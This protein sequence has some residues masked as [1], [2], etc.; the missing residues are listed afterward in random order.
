MASSEPRIQRSVWLDIHDRDIAKLCSEGVKQDNEITTRKK[1]YGW[2]FTSLTHLSEELYGSLSLC[3]YIELDFAEKEFKHGYAHSD[4]SKEQIMKNAIT[5][6]L[7][8][9]NSAS[10]AR[11]P[12]DL[13]SPTFWKAIRQLL[14]YLLGPSNPG[15]DHE[16]S[17]IGKDLPK[18]ST[19]SLSNIDKTTANITLLC[20]ELSIAPVTL[21]IKLLVIAYANVSDRLQTEGRKIEASC[22]SSEGGNGPTMGMNPFDHVRTCLTLLTLYLLGMRHS[23]HTRTLFVSSLYSPSATSATLQFL[24]FRLSPPTL[25]HVLLTLAFRAINVTSNPPHPPLSLDSSPQYW[26][27]TS[28]CLILIRL[29]L[30]WSIPTHLPLLSSSSPTTDQS[31]QTLPISNIESNPI[32]PITYPELFPSPRSIMDSSANSIPTVLSYVPSASPVSPH[33]IADDSFHSSFTHSF[34]QPSL[35][36]SMQHVDWSD[37]TSDSLLAPLSPL[38][39][40]HP[41]CSLASVPF[42][43]SSPSSLDDASSIQSH[44]SS[45]T[46]IPPSTFQTQHG[47]LFIYPGLFTPQQR[48]RM[49]GLCQSIS[50]SLRPLHY[51]DTTLGTIDSTIPLFTSTLSPQVPKGIGYFLPHNPSSASLPQPPL[52]RCASL[53]L[54]VVDALSAVAQPLYSFPQPTTDSPSPSLH[55]VDLPVFSKL[56]RLLVYVLASAVEGHITHTH[57]NILSSSFKGSHLPALPDHVT[58]TDGRR[59]CGSLLY[60]ASFLILHFLQSATLHHPLLGEF[61]KQKLVE[62]NAHLVIT[63]VLAKHVTVSAT[64]S[65]LLPRSLRSV[66]PLLPAFLFSNPSPIQSVPLTPTSLSTPSSSSTLSVNPSLP[67]ILPS[68]PAVCAYR[69]RSYLYQL[70]ILISLVAESPLHAIALVRC[71]II[72]VLNLLHHTLLHPSLHTRCLHLVMLVSRYYGALPAS[73]RPD[74]FKVIPDPVYDPLL[75]PNDVDQRGANLEEGLK[76]IDKRKSDRESSVK[77]LLGKMERMSQS[78]GKTVTAVTDRVNQS[79]PWQANLCSPSLGTGFPPPFLSSTLSPPPPPPPP[80]AVPSLPGLAC[81]PTVP[82]TSALPLLPPGSVPIPSPKQV[83]PGGDLPSTIYSTNALRTKISPD[84]ISAAYLS[85]LSSHFPSPGLF[86]NSSLSS[87]SS[88]SSLSISTSTAC[89]YGHALPTICPLHARFDEWIVSASPRELNLSSSEYRIHKA[90]HETHQRII[91]TFMNQRREQLGRVAVNNTIGFPLST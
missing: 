9:L 69:A 14:Y 17:K 51:I 31:N 59:V 87:S 21:F 64:S 86:P 52:T 60:S 13:A 45:V 38:E 56:L 75:T 1:L 41:P 12:R 16:E 46:P 10:L 81:V 19:T 88:S 18:E 28:K 29:G 25:L 43:L 44:S 74:S 3:D 33:Y 84:I 61:V 68:A 47:T 58:K 32:Q 57:T 26:D 36:S 11:S 67:S 24:P 80:L 30:M 37:E 70:D 85:S 6:S 35:R 55:F 8:L 5:D 77:A 4:L 79:H 50:I 7:E 82:H 62:S 78:L 91:A 71:G 83:N 73:L 2:Q 23:S 89:P 34:P 53:P 49:R 42:S 63:G 54:A 20:Q 90:G 48:L 15:S 27:I 72:P 22:S 39:M 40:N 65:P 66:L 76:R